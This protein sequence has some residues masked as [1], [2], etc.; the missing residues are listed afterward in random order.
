[1]LRIH[2]NC[3]IT[4]RDITLGNKVMETHKTNIRGQIHNYVLNNTHNYSIFIWNFPRLCTYGLLY[5]LLDVFGGGGVRDRLRLCPRDITAA[6]GTGSR[7]PLRVLERLLW[8]AQAS[9]TWINIANEHKIKG[10][11]RTLKVTI[12]KINIVPLDQTWCARRWIAQKQN[13]VHF[14][15]SSINIRSA[16]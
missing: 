11:R 6:F 5:F 12:Y 2:K 3:A 8:N 13:K 14:C 9:P 4:N 1:M 7:E 15:T 16:I 10:T